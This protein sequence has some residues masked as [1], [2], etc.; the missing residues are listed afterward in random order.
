LGADAELRVGKRF[1]NGH[2]LP[3]SL[4]LRHDLPSH[5]L[6]C[7]RL[8]SHLSGGGQKKKKEVSGFV[9]YSRKTWERDLSLLTNT[10]QITF[11]RLAQSSHKVSMHL[12][13]KCS[14]NQSVKGQDFLSK[15]LAS[16]A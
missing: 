11:S 8:C 2:L 13:I 5:F 12:S 9:V 6:V 7:Q 1:F 16:Y 14:E 15:I 4:F 10:D 3:S